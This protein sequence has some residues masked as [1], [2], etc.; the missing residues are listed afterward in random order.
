MVL[1]TATRGEGKT[2][3]NTAGKKRPQSWKIPQWRLDRSAPPPEHTKLPNGFFV[4]PISLFLPSEEVCLIYYVGAFGSSALPDD[5]LVKRSKKFTTE[6]SFRCYG[7]THAKF[8]RNEGRKEEVLSG[9]R[10]PSVCSRK[11]KETS[12]AKIL[13]LR[14]IQIYYTYVPFFQDVSCSMNS[15]FSLRLYV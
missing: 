7:T 4:L 6:S 3:L 9:V 11:R 1:L 10:V 14:Q 5:I 15:Q 13:S 8:R 12:F 2:F